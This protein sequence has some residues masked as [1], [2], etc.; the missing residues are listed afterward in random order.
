MKNLR[1]KLIAASAV[2]LAAAAPALAAEFSGGSEGNGES[3]RS[4]PGA[5]TLSERAINFNQRIDEGGPNTRSLQ[6]DPAAMERSIGTLGRKAGGETFSVPA[7]DEL[8]RT[9]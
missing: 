8:K 4:A 3:P 6:L 9:L 2:L 5:R 1:I 7:S